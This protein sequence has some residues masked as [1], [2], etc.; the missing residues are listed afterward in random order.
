MN[1]ISSIACAATIALSALTGAG[2]AQ[3]VGAV[4]T[5]AEELAPPP[6]CSED[7]AVGAA[8]EAGVKGWHLPAAGN[9]YFLLGQST[10]DGKDMGI[11]VSAVDCSIMR[12]VANPSEYR[13]W[14]H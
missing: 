13:P 8:Y 2:Q 1:R 3:N 4:G 10:S 7:Y 14:C 9:T 12:I 11:A 5:F 6:Y